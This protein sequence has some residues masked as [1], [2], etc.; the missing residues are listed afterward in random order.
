MDTL[1][2]AIENAI[3][4]LERNM[5]DFSIDFT[6]DYSL[7][8]VERHDLHDLLWEYADG[9]TPVYYSDIDNECTDEILDAYLTEVG[10]QTIECATDI[11]DIK[12]AA[13][14]YDLE[15]QLS[16]DEPEILCVLFYK[17]ILKALGEFKTY[18]FDAIIFAVET[19]LDKE[20][21]SL[22]VLK[23]VLDNE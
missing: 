6:Y 5:N 22:D 11:S 1:D 17:E 14:C 19:C 7:D 8:S 23:S 2:I 21:Y 3:I 4:E 13:I 9:A 12:A 18:S 10:S 16:D 15:R 20:E